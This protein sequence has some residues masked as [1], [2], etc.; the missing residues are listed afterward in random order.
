M[1]GFSG[2][3]RRNVDIEIEDINTDID[4][5]ED[6]DEDYDTDAVYSAAK[7]RGLNRSSRSSDEGEDGGEGNQNP[8]KRIVRNKQTKQQDDKTVM[9]IVIGVIVVLVIGIIV[10]FANSNKKKKQELLLLQQQQQS[11]QSSG[12]AEGT[13]KPG[14][15]NFYGVGEDENDDYLYNPNLVT[16]DL[17]G[18]QVP[19]N[20]V[21]I[22]SDEVTDYITYKK[23]RAATG[24]GLEF[25]WL[26]AE[27]KGQPYKVQVPYSV[28]SKLDYSGIT[29]VTMEV[30][31]LEGNS[32][33]ITYMTV[34][35]DAKSLLEG[36]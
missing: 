2:N 25:Y 6:E 32:K 16:K 33:M 28:Y 15:P 36:R 30:L 29:V 19:T 23:Y 8:N 1:A 17:N 35:E 24:N 10:F 21:V 18:N 11:Q 27:Y 20:Y 34:K 31:T 12:V 5:F 26:E 9:F 13:V 7:K 14:I 22:D 3:N 4:E